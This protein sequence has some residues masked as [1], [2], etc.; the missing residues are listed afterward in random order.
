[1]CVCKTN[2]S[3]SNKITYL[4]TQEPEP[5]HPSIPP[6]PPSLPSSLPPARPSHPIPSHPTYTISSA[7]SYL[8]TSLPSYLPS[9]LPTSLPPARLHSTNCTPP[10]AL[11]ATRQVRHLW[12]RYVHD[13]VDFSGTR[14]AG[15]GWDGDVEGVGDG[16]LRDGMGWDGMGLD[17]CG[18][19]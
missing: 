14:G 5:Y 17:I 7:P 9:Y 18:I 1:M 15:M 12:M 19:G 11:P 13:G 8:P 4:R 3:C 6:L 2:S 16:C 10:T